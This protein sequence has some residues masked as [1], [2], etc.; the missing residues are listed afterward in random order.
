[1]AACDVYNVEVCTD[2]VSSRASRTRYNLRPLDPVPNALCVFLYG[3]SAL[4]VEHMD[5]E[6]Q[7]RE[8]SAEIESLTAELETLRT[9]FQVGSA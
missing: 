3:N 7:L 5:N 1:M 8:M 4:Q 2:E 9:K 6:R